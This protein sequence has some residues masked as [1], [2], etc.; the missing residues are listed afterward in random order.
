MIRVAK[1]LLDDY[2]SLKLVEFIQEAISIA[3]ARGADK[4]AYRNRSRVLKETAGK[5]IRDTIL[6][7]YPQDLKDIVAASDYAAATPARL[8]TIVLNG[9]PSDP[10]LAISSSELQVLA[11]I[12][13]ELQVELKAIT[14][15]ADKFNVE[16]IVV[17]ENLLSLDILLPREAIENEAEKFA[18]NLSR[19][20]AIAIDLIE[21]VAGARDSPYLVYTST[22]DPVTAI[23]MIGGAAFGLFKFY[24]LALEV[25]EK[26]VSFL[27]LLRSIREAAPGSPEAAT[28]EKTFKKVISEEMPR[29]A[30]AAVQAVLS[31]VPE[32]R[33]NELRASLT[34]KAPAIVEA[35]AKGARLS[36]TIENLDRLDLL[37]EGAALVDGKEVSKEIL[38]QDMQ[39]RSALESKLDVETAALGA[40]VRRLLNAVENET[41]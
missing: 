34:L 32:G 39:E 6:N 35:V 8:A 22:T 23:A 15:A 26:Q 20:I 29:I 9:F 1:D 25:A 5:I 41:E 40:D 11:Q 27:R 21:L 12:A 13:A 31:K 38:L 7:K 2:S 16:P 28:L 36:I 3:T 10:N 4:N 33:T 37:L 30:G 24:K 14:R 17:P 18:K 19:F